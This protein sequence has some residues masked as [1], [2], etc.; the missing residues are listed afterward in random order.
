MGRISYTTTKSWVTQGTPGRYRR[1][2]KV[3]VSG[4]TNHLGR[5]GWISRVRLDGPPGCVWM[6]VR[7]GAA[8]CRPYDAEQHDV[9]RKGDGLDDVVLGSTALGAASGGVATGNTAW[10]AVDRVRGR[11]AGDD[12]QSQCRPAS[13]SVEPSNTAWGAVVR[14]GCRAA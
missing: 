4:D 1:A 8:R 3:T 6:I 7:R 2:E 5:K 10:G 14:I 9:M 13:G 11:H 12:C